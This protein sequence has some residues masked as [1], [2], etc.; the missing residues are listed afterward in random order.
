[1]KK[2]KKEKYYGISFSTED[3]LQ[4]A[5]TRTFPVYFSSV[6]CEDKDFECALEKK[7]ICLMNNKKTTGKKE[8]I[9][10]IFWNKI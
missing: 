2:T 4:W 9:E 1:M 5:K 8:I 7:S 10:K 3:F 6:F